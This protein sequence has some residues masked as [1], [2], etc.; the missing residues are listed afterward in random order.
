[1]KTTLELPD[2][3]MREV[4]FRAVEENRKLKDMIA[5]LLK[6]GLAQSSSGEQAVRGGRRATVFPL[7]RAAHPALPSEE[8]TPERV[9]DI[10][11]EQEI[12]R[13]FG[14]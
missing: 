11:L 5:D 12:D 13:A 14:R 3:L 4:K 7:V 8:M 6:K 10:L 1:M 9:A 2:E